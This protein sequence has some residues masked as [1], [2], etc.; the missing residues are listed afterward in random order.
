MIKKKSKK[1]VASESEEGDWTEKR[2]KTGLQQQQKKLNV[3]FRKVA[4]LAAT[5]QLLTYYWVDEKYVK[6]L[7]KKRR[8]KKD[9]RSSEKW[10]KMSSLQIVVALLLSFWINENDLFS[11][12]FLTP[13]KQKNKKKT[14]NLVTITEKKAWSAAKR[15]KGELKRQQ[16]VEEW[17]NTRMQP[18]RGHGK[19]HER[20]CPYRW[21][22]KKKR[23]KRKC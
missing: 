3:L 13:E 11:F 9:F 14:K 4:S 1:K 23:E 7:S 15:K 5:Q 22:K 8:R 20:L 16:G 21:Q 17:G 12:F 19:R 10:R 2:G 6:G 18:T